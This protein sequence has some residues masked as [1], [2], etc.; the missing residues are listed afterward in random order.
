MWSIYDTAILM[1]GIIFGVIAILPMSGVPAKTRLTAALAA[2]VLITAALYLGGLRSFRYPSFVFGGPVIALLY[3]GV[4]VVS[5]RSKGHAETGLQFDDRSNQ[6]PPTPTNWPAADP[7]PAVS[8]EPRPAP[9]GESA[10]T[11]ASAEPSV[12]PVVAEAPA[13][14]GHGADEPVE[15]VAVD[16]EVVVA[17]GEV[18]SARA[19]AWDQLHDPATSADRLVTLLSRY[20]EFGPSAL[21]HPQVYPELRQWIQEHT[22]T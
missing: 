11:P 19:A 9:M 16:P 10:S 5:A 14:R 7:I 8:A 18:D 12:P 3:L 2:A 13:L 22:L 20:P 21:D 15:S 17:S 1:T 6:A 4:V